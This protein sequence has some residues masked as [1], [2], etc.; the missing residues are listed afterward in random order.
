METLGA[1][2]VRTHGNVGP[3]VIVLHG[4]PG[5]KGSAGPLA[6]GLADSFRVIEP[7]QRE[8]GGEALTVARHV[9]DLHAVVEGCGGDE[10]AVV[11]HSWGAMLALAYSAAHP[12]PRLFMTRCG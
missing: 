8:S 7:W 6:K 2:R 5:A 3:S 12:D 11:G 4:G 10:L 9:A 1:S